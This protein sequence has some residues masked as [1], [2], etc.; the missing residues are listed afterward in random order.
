M[1]PIRFYQ[2]VALGAT[3]MALSIFAGCGGPQEPAPAE[4]EKTLQTLTQKIDS[5]EVGQLVEKTGGEFSRLTPEEQKSFINK[6][7]NGQEMGAQMVWT[8]RVN[9]NKNR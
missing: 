2:T 7:G 5:E 6:Y 9:K 4:K 1:T 8:A 3:V